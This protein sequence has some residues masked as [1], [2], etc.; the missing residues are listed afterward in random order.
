MK[1]VSFWG[2]CTHALTLNFQICHRFSL[3][4]LP[5]HKAKHKLLWGKMGGRD[6]ATKTEADRSPPLP[7]NTV[8]VNLVML[9]QKTCVVRF[10]TYN[11]RCS[12]LTLSKV[13]KHHLFKHSESNA[14]GFDQIWYYTL[15]AMTKHR[16]LIE[17]QTRS[18][19]LWMLQRQGYD[20][21]ISQAIA[22]ICDQNTLPR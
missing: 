8:S 18:G 5:W 3:V 20:G 15:A 12:L 22:V 13:R 9:R 1:S 19:C 16:Y 2:E 4:N 6:G 17:L 10:G 14:D 11:W 7:T 21:I